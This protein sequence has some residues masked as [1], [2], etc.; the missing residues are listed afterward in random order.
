MHGHWGGSDQAVPGKGQGTRPG[1]AVGTREGRLGGCWGSTGEGRG[2]RKQR[3]KEGSWE[4]D[5]EVLLTA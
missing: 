2:R 3:V 1:L 4:K 5:G